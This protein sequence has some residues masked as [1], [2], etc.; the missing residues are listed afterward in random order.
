LVWVEPGVAEDA[1][2]GASL[3]FSMQ[4]HREGRSVVVMLQPNVAATLPRDLP[5]CPF[6]GLHKALA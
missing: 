1:R 2:E 4:R 6:E 3:E 5:P